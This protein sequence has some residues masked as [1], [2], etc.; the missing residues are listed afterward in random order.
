MFLKFDD[1]HLF[2][3]VWIRGHWEELQKGLLK[4]GN[5]MKNRTERRSV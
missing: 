2:K 3:V 1:I 5:K 4:L